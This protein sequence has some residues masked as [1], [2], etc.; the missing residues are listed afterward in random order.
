MIT[1]IEKKEIDKK[2]FPNGFPY[3][4]KTFD[5]YSYS[6]SKRLEEPFENLQEY[7]AVVKSVRH[8][9]G[10]RFFYFIKGL[11]ENDFI[12]EI[13]NQ[14]LNYAIENT[15]NS[16]HWLSLTY[17]LVLK[18]F[19]IAGAIDD[20]NLRGAFIKWYN[21]T[22]NE[23]EPK[24]DAPELNNNTAPKKVKDYKKHIWFTTGIKLA[25]G[26]AYDLYNK[27]NKGHF[28]KICLELGFK[29]TDRPYFSDTINE[30]TGDK[31]TFANPD[32]VK[33]LHQYLT[34]NNLNC[35]A[36]FLSKYNQIELE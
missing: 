9:N 21:I 28:K 17:D 36:V 26:E 6:N 32:K 25:T 30:N 35:G 8:S 34:E 29:E 24:N 22:L 11:N 16:K 13:N 7:E 3:K 5:T 27:Y 4:V 18:G 12:K 23:L 2:Y 20:I 10:L 1:E 14:Y 31:N 19:S 15:E 33:K